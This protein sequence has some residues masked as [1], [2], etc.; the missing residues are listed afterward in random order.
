MLTKRWFWGF[1]LSCL[2]VLTAATLYRSCVV[3]TE[4]DPVRLKF[5]AKPHP[6]T[7]EE[8]R[9]ETT[10]ERDAPTTRPANQDAT[11]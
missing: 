2:S 4:E 7:R 1:V 3:M 5:L 10:E 9:H 6:G 11:N 8:D